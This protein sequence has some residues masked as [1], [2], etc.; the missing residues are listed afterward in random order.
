MVE[1]ERRSRDYCGFLHLNC[2]VFLDGGQADEDLL[3]LQ[4]E[5]SHGS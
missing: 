4:G 5:V 2:R 3:Q 1:R